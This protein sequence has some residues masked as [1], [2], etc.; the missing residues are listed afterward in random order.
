MI[1]LED[2]QETPKPNYT[3]III[4]GIAALL[5]IIVGFISYK[6]YVDAKADE[7]IAQTD[8]RIKELENKINEQA[9]KPANPAPVQVKDP[10]V[11]KLRREFEALKKR[12]E[13]N[14]VKVERILDGPPPALAGAAAELASN[15]NDPSNF[16]PP[17]PD[18]ILNPTPSAPSSVAPPA[19][20][21]PE[22]EQRMARARQQQQE[23]IPDYIRDSVQ[24]APGG[25][26]A[27]ARQEL[28]AAQDQIRN[29][30]AIGKVV[31]FD[32]DWN[33]VTVS[34]GDRS[35]VEEG[36]RYSI[37]RG[38]DLIGVVK[39]QRVFPEE[40]IAGLVTKSND[41]DAAVKP[42]AGDDVILY[43]PY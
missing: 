35:N 34:A 20:P 22:L 5:L 26:S 31:S 27:R 15:N 19:L 37:R 10:E 16:L 33:F 7:R 24:A 30:P 1:G 11:E 32:P 17:I 38:V 12:S 41:Y 18:G 3:P 8:E 9:A 13:E 36:Q 42:Q 23:A 25:M 39:I 28:S 6:D 14:T 40:S 29:A 43:E 2:I 21:D 4:L